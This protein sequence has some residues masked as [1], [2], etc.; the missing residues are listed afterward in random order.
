MPRV[1]TTFIK[2]LSDTSIADQI[3]QFDHKFN[4][5]GK[6]VN[7]SAVEVFSIQF[8]YDALSP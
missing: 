8:I 3:I 4:E 7:R 6:N 5:E 1:E 2:R